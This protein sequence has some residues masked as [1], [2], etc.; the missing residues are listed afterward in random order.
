MVG[1]VPADWI[2]ML[3]DGRMKDSLIEAYKTKKKV[4]IL[5]V[6]LDG[7]RNNSLVF[8]VFGSQG[9]VGDCTKESLLR[10]LEIGFENLLEEGVE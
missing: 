9:R 7:L 3:G 2:L 4:E 10:C 6:K 1:G 5:Q 8:T